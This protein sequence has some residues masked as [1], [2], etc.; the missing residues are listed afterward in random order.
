MNLKV[1]EK[2][3][4]P[5][6][7][8]GKIKSTIAGCNVAARFDT[9]SADMNRVGVDLMV[10]GG[11]AET[12]VQIKGSADMVDLT[13]LPDMDISSVRLSQSVDVLGGTFTVQPGYNIR[14]E[15]PDIKVAYAVSGAAVVV[16]ANAGR[17][18]LTVVKALGDKNRI[19]P[20]ITS[21][22]DV[23]LQ[24]S[25]AIRDG[26]LTATMQPKSSLNLS[27]SEGKWNVNLNAPLKG[28]SVNMGGIKL[29][30]TCNG[31]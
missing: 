19:A 29:S 31:I 2:G 3:N 16:D 15:Q 20:S 10:T 4:M 23:A 11:P 17:Q 25:R 24:Y 14:A 1:D 5:Y 7:L 28:T 13:R 27:W 6:T 18:K 8:W 12:T 26:T 22:G 21:D 9:S 30:A